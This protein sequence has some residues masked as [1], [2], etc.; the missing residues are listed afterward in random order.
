MGKKIFVVVVPF[1]LVACENSSVGNSVK[2]DVYNSP[3][4]KTVSAES[5]IPEC[6]RPSQR[7][8]KDELLFSFQNS[9]DTVCFYNDFPY[10]DTI[11]CFGE[12]A[13][14]LQREKSGIYISVSG[15]F[16]IG[17]SYDT[18]TAVEN[19]LTFSKCA[20]FIGEERYIAVKIGTQTWLAENARGKDRCLFDDDENCKL[21][22]ML[23][24]YE[25]AKEFCS[26][27]FRLP[28]SADIEKLLHSVGAEIK[29]MYRSGVC[30][31]IPYESRY[32][33]VSLFIDSRDSTK[34]NLNG[35]SFFADGGMLEKKLGGSSLVY[36]KEKTCFFLQSDEN[37]GYV[38][39]FCYSSEEKSAFVTT[40]EK[41]SELYVRCIMK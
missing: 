24:P 13:S 41:D 25:K 11:C 5:I 10:E 39:A 28:T 33:N 29:T 3:N 37:I 14:F 16:A 32:Y 31:K 7:F 8:V 19:P 21:F 2:E 34:E 38:N 30:G 36:S 9:S 35:F 23:M 1:L 17:S 15:D 22:G 18:L 26:N 20:T 6:E 27:D 12:A 40:L 4:E